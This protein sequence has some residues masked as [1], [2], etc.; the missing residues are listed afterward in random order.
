LT[1]PI[2]ISRTNKPQSRR[3]QKV[4]DIYKEER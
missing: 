1:E 4:K 2:G 3:T